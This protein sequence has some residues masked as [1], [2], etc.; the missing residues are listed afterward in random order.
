[1][2]AS[3]HHEERKKKQREELRAEA[4]FRLPRSFFSSVISS[5]RGLDK[6]REDSR[7]S[8]RPVCHDETTKPNVR[9]HLKIYIEHNI[10]QLSFFG[11]ERRK[12]A[13]A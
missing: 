10:S 13:D 3:L 4:Y 6:R 5:A 8:A 11:Y 7:L 12:A 2:A 1:M 9:V